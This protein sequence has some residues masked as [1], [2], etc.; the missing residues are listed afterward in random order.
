M[1]GTA[2]TKLQLPD[3]STVVKF[4]DTASSGSITISG[5]ALRAD[6]LIVGGGGGGGRSLAGGGG[7]GGVVYQ[8]NVYLAAGTYTITVGAGGAALTVN[9][10]NSGKSSNITLS[11]QLLALPN[12]VVCE[13]KGGGGGGGE[14]NYVAIQLSGAGSGGSGGGGS[15]DGNFV[16]LPVGEATQ[17]NT[18]W[19]GIAN[20]PGGYRGEAGCPSTAMGGSGGGSAGPH[21]LQPKCTNGSQGVGLYITGSLQYYAA[22]G[23]GYSIRAPP[24]QISGG[25][26]IGGSGASCQS[27]GA[28]KNS[29]LNGADGTGSGGGGGCYDYRYNGGSN[30]LGGGKGGSGVVILRLYT[31]VLVPSRVL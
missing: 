15:M 7:A 6:I 8:Q 21:S 23:S 28:C 13:G 4:N 10:G 14:I 18:Y 20:S 12:G 16:A 9:V 2:V 11:G 24:V 27:G 25:S 29:N 5:T 22:G 3:G 26:G 30:C 1:N 17:G 19:N 31:Q